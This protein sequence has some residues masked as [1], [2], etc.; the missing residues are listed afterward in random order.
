M[1]IERRVYTLR[2][3]MQDAFWRAQQE[4][5]FELVKPILDRLIGYFHWSDEA[6]T[7]ITHLYRYDS[8]DDWKQRLHGLYV[9]KALEPYFRTVRTLMTAQENKMLEPAP[10]AELSPFWGHRRDWQ[11]GEG[12]LFPSAAG[13]VEE[14]T[15]TFMPGGLPMFWQACQASSNLLALHAADPSLIGTF[16][17]VIGRQHQVLQYRLKTQ[18]PESLAAVDAW[19]SAVE[20]ARAKLAGI[21]VRELGLAPLRPLTPL[22]NTDS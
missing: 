7:Q 3:G 22:F 11:R 9:V 12:P 8:F 15:C 21:E 19:R 5:G 2:P 1:L 14:S 6:G 18:A 17:S 10:L 16:V 13:P 4:R 20:S